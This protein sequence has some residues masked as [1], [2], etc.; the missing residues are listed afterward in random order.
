MP[1]IFASPAELKAA[2]GQKFGPTEWLLVDQARIDKFAEATGD[3]QWI[4]V[5][6]ERAAAGPYGTTI[7]HGF[8]TLALAALFLP[9]LIEVQGIKHG[10]N[11]GANKLRFPA[12][13][14]CGARIRGRGELLSAEDVDGGGVQ[15]IIRL[16]IDVDDGDKPACVVDKIARF[17]AA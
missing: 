5:D 1:H 13:V 4:H 8:L 14:R 11:Y 12:P 10:L 15:V 3:F 17:Y 2:V 16:T 9:Q 7:A 6:P